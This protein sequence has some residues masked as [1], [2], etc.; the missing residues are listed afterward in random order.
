LASKVERRWL[1]RWS[2]PRAPSAGSR[3]P[4]LSL[5]VAVENAPRGIPDRSG[6]VEQ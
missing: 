2:A 1:S 4:R 6:E 3:W 5:T